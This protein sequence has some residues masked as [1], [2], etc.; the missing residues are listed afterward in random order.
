MKALFTKMD[1]IRD[2]L[3][4]KIMEVDEKVNFETNDIKRKL[5]S[6]VKKTNTLLQ[7]RDENDGISLDLDGRR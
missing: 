7:K 1:E 3:G 6:I 4:S 5:K 2:H